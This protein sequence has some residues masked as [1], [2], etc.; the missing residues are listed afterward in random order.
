VQGIIDILKSKGKL[1]AVGLM[2]IGL[3][4]CAYSYFKGTGE[5]QIGMTTF[6]LG[7]SLLGI[8]GKQG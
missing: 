5:Y 6:F 1:G 3:G 7:L 8:R 4:M 2:L